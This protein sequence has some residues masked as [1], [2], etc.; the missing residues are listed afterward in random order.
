MIKAISSKL[1]P[2]KSK[3]ISTKPIKESRNLTSSATLSKKAIITAAIA[4]K[5]I[6]TTPAQAISISIAASTA[7]SAKSNKSE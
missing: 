1:I 7:V 4:I 5:T 2:K 6:P 3:S